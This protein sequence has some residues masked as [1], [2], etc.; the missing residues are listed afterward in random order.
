MPRVPE[1]CFDK[2]AGSGKSL[3]RTGGPA[4]QDRAVAL[5]SPPNDA[6]VPGSQTNSFAVGAALEV[7]VLLSRIAKEQI[8]LAPRY[9]RKYIWP[10]PK[11]HRLI[12]SVMGNL[13]VP[14]IVLHTNQNDVRLPAWG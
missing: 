9:Q 11:A 7:D 1:K 13:Y 8:N 6:N 5:L 12:E 3:M 2:P 10:N 4:S 14:G